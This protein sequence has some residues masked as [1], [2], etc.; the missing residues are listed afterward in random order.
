MNSNSKYRAAFDEY[1]RLVAILND[2]NWTNGDLKSIELLIGRSIPMREGNTFAS[3]YAAFGE[4]IVDAVADALEA[5]VSQKALVDNRGWLSHSDI[6]GYVARAREPRAYD[7]TPTWIQASVIR[8]VKADLKVLVETD[9]EDAEK[10]L[11]AAKTFLR[12]WVQQIPDQPSEA[13]LRRVA[14]R[15]R[16]EH[17]ELWKSTRRKLV[18]E[19]D[20]LAVPVS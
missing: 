2:E 15:W 3:K 18:N 12:R 20:Q 10:L 14:T 6:R 8:A 16:A 19:I 7:Y 1:V 5:G 4:A 11:R 17:V 9:Q 13:Q